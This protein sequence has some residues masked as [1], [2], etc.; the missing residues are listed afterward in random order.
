MS[1]DNGIYILRSPS[2]NGEEYRV[3]EAGAID[4]IWLDDN[5]EPYGDLIQNNRKF[6]PKML[7]LYFGNAPVFHDKKAALDEAVRLNDETGWT[8]YGI[9]EFYTDIPFRE[10]IKLTR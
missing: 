9:C 1:S 7:K 6:N 8:E 3:I 2:D 10:Y 4:N 5:G